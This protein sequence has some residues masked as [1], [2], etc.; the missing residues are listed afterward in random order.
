MNESLEVISGYVY[1]SYWFNLDLVMFEN[2]VYKVLVRIF[3][4]FWLFI[5][6]YIFDYLSIVIVIIIFI[7]IIINVI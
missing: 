3:F 1:V 7:V 2:M 4:C 6:L 5:I